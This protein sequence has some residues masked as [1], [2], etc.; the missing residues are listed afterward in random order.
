MKTKVCTKCG[1][2]L[3]ATSDYFDRDKYSKDGLRSSC[4]ECKKAYRRYAK[5]KIKEYN[6]LYRKIN[7]EM[8]NT[9]NRIYMK[10]NKDKI[11]EYRRKYNQV[12]KER[13]NLVNQIWYKATYETNKEMYRLRKL[14]R[15]ARLEKLEST[16]TM[17]QWE[18]TKSYFNFSCAYCGRKKR[19]LEQDH[20]IPLI[21]N[22]PYTVGNIIPACRSCNGSK[23]DNDFF[24]W[25]PNYLYYNKEREMAILKYFKLA[26]V[27][28][29]LGKEFFEK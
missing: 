4:K 7:R 23:K 18:I 10:E 12:H 29:H 22:G 17:E 15:K 24:E 21:K 9:H 27:N 28:L 16:L 3:F 20:F 5:D 2:V 26:G 1:M 8:L 13:R 14:K 11:N 6:K 25:Y 19:T